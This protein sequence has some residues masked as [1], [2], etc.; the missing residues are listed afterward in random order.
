MLI[1]RLPSDIID[2]ILQY[3]AMSWQDILRF[4]GV[5]HSWREMSRMSIVWLTT[6]LTFH[7]PSDYTRI[8]QRLLL[9]R[10]LDQAFDH[11]KVM[12]IHLPLKQDQ[13]YTYACSEVQVLLTF[14]DGDNHNKSLSRP[15]PIIEISNTFCT[16]LKEY[17][18]YWSF[19]NKWW[20]RLY[21]LLIKID[22]NSHSY[23]TFLL[24]SF[25][26]LLQA[27]IA[28]VYYSYGIHT[29]D[30]DD[31]NSK[32]LIMRASFALSYF[33]VLLYAFLYLLDVINILAEILLE[34]TETSFYPVFYW[35]DIVEYYANSLFMFAVLGCWFMLLFLTQMK[36]LYPHCDNQLSWTI[37]T[38]PVWILY[39]MHLIPIIDSPGMKSYDSSFLQ[40][41][42]FSLIPLGLLPIP[43]TVSTISYSYDYSIPLDQTIFPSLHYILYLY[44]VFMIV[45][46]FIS[47]ILAFLALQSI[48]WPNTRWKGTVTI[49]IS[50]IGMTVLYWFLIKSNNEY[51]NINHNEPYLWFLFTSF[52]AC[53]HIN[54][55]TILF[56]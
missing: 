53:F 10:N 9:F 48:E 1:S 30:K 8:Y 4:G 43:L 18:D 17:N 35:S 21:K 42:V 27:F 38:F 6:D 55:G 5:C 20:N 15:P 44:G 23:R 26:L 36:L 50:G 14:S 33:P 39:L 3:Y 22:D 13:V 37:V 2:F 19:Y 45:Y 34:R 29:N 40:S 28:F 31:N 51:T 24:S 47:S 12:I 54:I 46:T 49:I 41:L 11:F 56:E 7:A 32:W 52:L 16:L 25:F